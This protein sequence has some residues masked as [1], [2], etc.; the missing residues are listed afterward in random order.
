MAKPTA[1]LFSLGAKGTLADA[2]TYSSW[3]GVPY[4]RTRV[5]PANPRTTKQ[6]ERRDAF[7]V[8]A[9][10]WNYAPVQL[11]QAFNA[12]AAGQP[13]TGRNRFMGLNLKG[14]IPGDPWADTIAVSDAISGALPPLTIVGSDATGH[15]MTVTITT[16]NVPTGWNLTGVHAVAALNEDNDDGSFWT[17]KGGS[18]S[19]SPV[20][21]GCGAAGDYW[22]GA[23]IEYTDPQGITR[24]SRS[25]VDPHVTLA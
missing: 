2:I 15:N 23:Y 4:V 8:L 6:V 1:P 20:T 10:A 17:P 13:Y 22:V 7:S 16:S 25:L 14:I 19:G 5:I 11:L 21:V 12:A 24:Y 9:N 3:K 18:A